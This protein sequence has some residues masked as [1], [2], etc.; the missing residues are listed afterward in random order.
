M[1]EAYHQALPVALSAAS[2]TPSLSATP[3]SP[4]EKKH[5]HFIEDRIIN[6]V[7]VDPPLDEELAKVSPQAAILKREMRRQQ[8]F[9]MRAMLMRGFDRGFNSG[10]R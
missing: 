10:F 9:S 8:G 5:Y 6:N 1:W 2:A 7:D 4:K 3:A